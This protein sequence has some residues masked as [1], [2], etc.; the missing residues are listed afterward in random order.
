MTA[1]MLAEEV[2]RLD[3]EIKRI[4]Q[5]IATGCS[6]IVD[7]ILLEATRRTRASTLQALL[8]LH[9]A[10]STLPGIAPAPSEIFDDAPSRS[11]VRRTVEEFWTPAERLAG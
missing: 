1:T 7:H 9:A 10:R 6:G 8:E 5:R 2:A 4:Q 11:G 3:A